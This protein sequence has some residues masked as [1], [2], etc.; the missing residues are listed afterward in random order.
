MPGDEVPKFIAFPC[1]CQFPRPEKVV[2][3]LPKLPP[4]LPSPPKPPRTVAEVPF[5]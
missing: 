5:Y 3:E 2:E 4:P 1:P